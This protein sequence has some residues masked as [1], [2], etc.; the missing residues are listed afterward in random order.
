MRMIQR[1]YHLA[2]MDRILCNGRRGVRCT[3]ERE[4][5]T[6]LVEAENPGQFGCCK[7]PQDTR[8]RC[9]NFTM[10]WYVWYEFP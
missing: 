4:L 6:K 8:S 9:Y 5:G 10:V 3:E 7:K 1:K 2:V